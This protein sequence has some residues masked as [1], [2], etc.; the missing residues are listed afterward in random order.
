MLD[1]PQ[2]HELKFDCRN[3]CGE[4]RITVDETTS[5][6][7]I[8]ADPLRFSVEAMCGSCEQPRRI[9]NVPATAAQSCL[10]AGAAMRTAEPTLSDAIQQG[11]A[12]GISPF[13]AYIAF[14]A[15]QQAQT[16]DGLMNPG[17]IAITPY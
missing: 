16:V 11:M 6:I 8:E 2:Q 14:K 9:D 13:D 10:E 5:V 1:T 4:Q 17:P 3:G 15:I 12:H 7:V